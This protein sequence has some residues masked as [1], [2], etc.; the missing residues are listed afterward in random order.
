VEKDLLDIRLERE[1]AL[2]LEQRLELLSLAE[3][4]HP[5]GFLLNCPPAASV[6]WLPAVW[7][8]F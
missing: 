8:A 7:R 4:C 2:E 6:F 1:V 5:P 3:G